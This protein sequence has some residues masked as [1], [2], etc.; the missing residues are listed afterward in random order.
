[1][2]YSDIP[3]ARVNPAPVLLVVGTSRGFARRCRD[4]AISGQALVVETDV[5][6]APTVAAQ[7]RPLALLL[8]EEIFAFDPPSFTGLA[9]AVRAQVVVVPNEDIDQSE[10]ESLILNAILQ[11]EAVRGSFH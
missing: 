5:A 8:S 9:S 11:A 2:T 10:L 3:T 7:T 6:S 1:V 4:A